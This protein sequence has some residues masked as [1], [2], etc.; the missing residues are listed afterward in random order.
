MHHERCFD[1]DIE[2]HLYNA[3]FKGLFYQRKSLQLKCS[4]LC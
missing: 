4:L 3:L 2:V 1:L